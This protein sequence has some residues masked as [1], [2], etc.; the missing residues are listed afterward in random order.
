MEKIED[1]LEAMSPLEGLFYRDTISCHFIPESVDISRY[2]INSEGWKILFHSENTSVNMWSVYFVL[3][4]YLDF[5]K[6]RKDFRN[7]DE[8]VIFSCENVFKLINADFPNY[9]TGSIENLS[10]LSKLI[11]KNFPQISEA[12]SGENIKKTYYSLINRDGNN[13]K[14]VNKILKTIK[15]MVD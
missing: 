2:P 9:S 14:E 8:L 10:E 1:I 12:F 4:P 15:D 7:K 13:E 5:I 3:L 11:K 6:E